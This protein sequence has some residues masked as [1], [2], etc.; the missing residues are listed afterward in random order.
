MDQ[1]KFIKNFDII[2][3]KFKNYKNFKDLSIESI[4]DIQKI[5]LSTKDDLQNFKIEDCPTQPVA[6]WN[7]SGSSGNVTLIGVS[8]QSYNRF[9]KRAD[10][11]NEKYLGPFKEGRKKITNVIEMYTDHYFIDRGF[12]VLSSGRALLDEEEIDFFAKRVS[13]A[14]PNILI[15]PPSFIYSILTRLKERSFIDILFIGGQMVTKSFIENL[16]QM[17]DAKLVET[18][19]FTEYPELTV[20]D[21]LKD[22]YFEVV[23]NEEV[24]LEVMDLKG[25]FS[26]QGKGRLIISDLD[27]DSYPIIRYLVGDVVELKEEDGKRFIKVFGR[28]DSYIKINQDLIN[29][30]EIKNNILD[31]LAHDEYLVKIN[32]EKDTLVDSIEICL[33]EEDINKKDRI[34]FFINDHFDI[35]PTFQELNEPIKTNRRGKNINVI[36]L[37]ININ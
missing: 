22:E 11:F 25:N 12:S 26:N 18:Y 7:T 20:R 37:R 6:I 24:Y 23:P 2:V 21:P 16:S 29:K 4:E 1:E 8:Q 17:V 3:K 13:I 28:A 30:D 33:K 15:G 19:C 10:L 9:I 14:K 5:P 34:N 27:N 35:S 32:N 36:D 31:I